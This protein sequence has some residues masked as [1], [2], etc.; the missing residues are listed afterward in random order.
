MEVEKEKET[1]EEAIGGIRDELV[2]LNKEIVSIRNE[3]R[4]LIEIQ[5][6]L[7]HER[8]GVPPPPPPPPVGESPKKYNSKKIYI[9]VLGEGVSVSG[10]TFNHKDIIKQWKNA[11][12]QDDKSW[13]LPSGYLE[14]LISAFEDN[15]LKEDIDFFVD[16][17]QA[18]QV[19]GNTDETSMF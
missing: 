11:K 18:M 12:F 7:I 8:L 19:S 15:G 3:L 5:Q 17:K 16:S 1:T 9:K 4:G 13:L 6:R 2:K 14:K 10:N